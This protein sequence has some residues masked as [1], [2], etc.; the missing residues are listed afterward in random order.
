VKAALIEQTLLPLTP[1]DRILL[2]CC[3]ERLDATCQQF[4]RDALRAGPDGQRLLARAIYHRLPGLL[5]YH[6]EQSGALDD[7]PAE[8]RQSLA[9]EIKTLYLVQQQQKQ[10]LFLCLERLQARSVDVMLLKGPLLQDLYPPGVGRASH[11]LDLLIREEHLHETMSVLREVGYELETR[12]PDNLTPWEAVQFSHYVEQLRFVR[13]NH[14]PI[15]LHLRL[16][17][18]GVPDRLE[19]AWEHLRFWDVEG[20]QVP[21]LPPEE[22][23][24]YLTTHA[25]LHAFGRMLWYYDVTSLYWRWRDQLDWD[26]VASRASERRLLSSFYHSLLWIN[27][28]VYPERPVPELEPLRPSPV[29][30]RMFELLWHKEDT[31]ALR[32]YIRPFDAATYYLLG[33]ASPLKKL[34]YILRVLFPPRRWLAA[35]LDRP[36]SR[37]ISLQYLRWRRRESRS[38][39]RGPA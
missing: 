11:D 18:Y 7:L 39:G 33:A 32:S 24:L 19:R 28:L 31:F 26:L 25:N 36:S 5:R 29:R 17:N 38:A 16:H 14:T 23:L 22:L 12:I 30:T 15:E 21:S 6:L 1:E 8:V 4:L 2:L 9:D 3:R 13:P 20:R 37:L 34:R 10:G 27:Q 35:H